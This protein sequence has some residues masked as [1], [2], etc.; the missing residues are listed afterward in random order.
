MKSRKK[1]KLVLR[2]TTTLLVFGLGGV[3]F[4]NYKNDNVE[5]TVTSAS[6]QTT[7]F[8]QT[9]S[10]TAI[11]ISKTYDLYASV[12]LAQAILESSSGQSDLSRAPNLYLFGIQGEI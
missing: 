2:L 12:L 11:E 1:D 10:P 7:T 4:Y 6:D 5:P 8:I 9:I 3:W